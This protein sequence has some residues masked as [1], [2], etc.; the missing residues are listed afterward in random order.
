MAYHSTFT[1]NNYK[2]IGDTALLPLRTKI[3]GPAVKTNENYDIIDEVLLFFKANI[4]FKSFTIQ[5][6]ADR[7][8]IYITLYITEVLKKAV[9][10]QNKNNTVK[11]LH[12]MSIEKFSIPGDQS[13][14]LK[15]LYASPANRNEEAEIRGYLTQVRQEVNE[16]LSTI[17]FK[18]SDK[19]PSKW[20]TCFV[21]RKFMD[22]S[23]SKAGQ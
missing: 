15:G 3:R 16:R 13:F 8:L 1:N 14:P 10:C 18:D 2:V 11:E 21:K 6:E 17:L 22:K 20:W 4:L 9:K 5:S 19:K 12:S 7:T 23:L